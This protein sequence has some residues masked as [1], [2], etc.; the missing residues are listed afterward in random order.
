MLVYL[1][2][3]YQFSFRRVFEAAALDFDATCLTLQ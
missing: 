1:R 2:Q 3:T